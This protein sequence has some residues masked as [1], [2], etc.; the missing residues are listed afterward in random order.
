MF[1]RFVSGFLCLCCASVFAVQIEDVEVCQAM[2]TKEMRL[3][4]YDMIANEVAGRKPVEAKGVIEPKLMQRKHSI[5][6]KNTDFGSWVEDDEWLT[7]DTG[8]KVVE[9]HVDADDEIKLD[10][11]TTVRPS[12]RLQCYG[13]E[14]R[15]FIRWGAYLGTGTRQV[16]YRFDNNQ[17]V[18]RAWLISSEGKSTFVE[19][20]R[21]QGFRDML[22]RSKSLTIGVKPYKGAPIISRF[23]IYGAGAVLARLKDSCRI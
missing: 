16:T 3:D 15:Y 21:R 18:D 23:D 5:H 6:I 12:I 22:W 4:C 14:M 11:F 7:R 9:F 17:Q 20:N 10:N 13:N 8:K 19:K 1:K 2:A